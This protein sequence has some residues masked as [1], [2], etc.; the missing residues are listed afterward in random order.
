MVLE[1][2]GEAMRGVS[3]GG[4]G[5]TGWNALVWDEEGRGMG[6]TLGGELEVPGKE[7]FDGQLEMWVWQGS[8]VCYLWN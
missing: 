8:L 3:P 1:G 5:V 6:S 2:H 4:G 7:G